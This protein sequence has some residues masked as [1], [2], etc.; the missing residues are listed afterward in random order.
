VKETR[1]A[2]TQRGP[3]ALSFQAD[4]TAKVMIMKAHL[5]VNGDADLDDALQLRISNLRL[6]GG[7]MAATLA[8]GF[9]Q[10]RFD[11]IQQKPIAVGALALGEIRLRDVAVAIEGQTI[12]ISAKF[13][14]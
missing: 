1:L 4:V 8:R 13:G 12:S 9:L 5:T 11:K 3:R 7:G 14:S 2:F 10:P 6:T